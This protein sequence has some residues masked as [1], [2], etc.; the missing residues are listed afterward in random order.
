VKVAFTDMALTAVNRILVTVLMACALG[1]GAVV[2]QQADYDAPPVDTLFPLPDVEGAV[3]WEVLLDVELVFEG[4]DLVPEYSEEARAIDGETVKMVGF[5]LPLD[6]TGT[7]QLLSMVSPNCPFCLPGGPNT[8]V[9]LI[10]DEPVEWTD[11][12]VVVSGRFEL[13]EDSLSGYYYR[14]TEVDL[15]DDPSTS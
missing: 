3:P 12:A 15:V 14:M 7:R 8:F 10:A 1:G 9:E 4:I 2:A 6:A 13:L 5:L 11:D